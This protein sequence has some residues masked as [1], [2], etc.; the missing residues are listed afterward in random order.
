[1]MARNPIFTGRNVLLERLRKV[2]RGGGP[3]VVQALHG[4]GG[5][6]KTALAIEYAHAC[7]ADY[8]VVWWVHAEEPTLISDRLAELACALGLAERLSRPG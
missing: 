7:S 5:I 1:M 2:L 3:T 6:G 4:M 8:E